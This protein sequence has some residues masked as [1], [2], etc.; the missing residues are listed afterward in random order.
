MLRFRIARK[1]ADLVSVI[2]VRMMFVLGLAIVVAGCQLSTQEDVA[3]DAPLK[4]SG[5]SEN[6]FDDALATFEDYFRGLSSAEKIDGAFTCVSGALEMFAT[7]GRGSTNRESFSSNELRAFLERHFLRTTKLSDGFMREAMRV[8]Q[9]LLGGAGDRLT[10]NEITRLTQVLETLRIETQRLRPHVDILN[11]K[12][13]EDGDGEALEN[14]LFDLAQTVD[15]LGILLGQSKEPYTLESFKALLFEVQGLYQSTSDWRGPAWFAKQMPLVAAAKAVL[16]RPAGEQ[17]APDEWK[18]LFSHAGRLYGLYL[19]Y[20]YAI[21]GRDLFYGDGLRQIRISV[22]EVSRILEKAIAAKGTGRVDIALLK[23]F[24]EQ[25]EA[26][27]VFNLPVRASTISN[28]LEP[29]LERILNPF[30]ATR[31]IGGLLDPADKLSAHG[32]RSVQDGLTMTNLTVLRD[33]LLGWIEM[34][35]L[36]ERLETEAV[37]QSP[38]LAGRAI[39]IAT[40]RKLWASYSGAT[41]QESWSDLK[42][43]FDRPLPTSI[44]AEGRL[45]MV[46]TAKVTFDRN[47]F[48]A[49]NWKQQIV[50]TLG[51]GYVSD[52]KNLRMKGITLSQLK[53]V[54]DDFFELTIDLKF[55]DRTDGDIWKTGFTIASIFLFSSDGDDRLGFHEAVDLFVFSFGSSAIAKEMIRPEVFGNCAWGD[56]NS[57]GLPRIKS[58]CW[59]REVRRGYPTYFETLPGWTNLV[60]GWNDERWNSFFSDFEKASRK[61]TNPSGP[62]ASGE[63]DRAISIHH[64]IEALYTRW[65]SNGDGRLSM[66][67]ADKA[68]YLFKKILKD[69]SGFKDDKEVRALYFHLLVFG[70]PPESFSNK[71]YWLWWKENPDE[72]E[73]RTNAD[74]R[75]LVQIFGNLASA[76]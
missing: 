60:K 13:L 8:K 56:P 11:R 50:R 31:L 7:Y 62:M 63:M 33:T 32:Y 29:F 22:L 40:V 21:A 74:R 25:L 71:L 65:D 69:A 68:F 19:R 47:S 66:A 46:P 43:L 36:W 9:S 59:R 42:S 35:Q 16:I 23:N 27:E 15:E 20:S 52:P 38:R 73:K 61:P 4:L 70:K 37:A 5:P 6:C 72:W 3:P 55:L 30:V 41:H 57:I 39:P 1:F 28:L 24:F 48:A 67:E 49:L 45:M 26:S 75:I 18:M 64:Y 10:K 54:F 34:Q 17:I 51:T 58:D 12:V 2:L 53:E 44:D 76:L 14:A